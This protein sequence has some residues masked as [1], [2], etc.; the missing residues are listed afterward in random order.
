MESEQ[1]N[2]PQAALGYGSDMA[3]AKGQAAMVLG[4]QRRNRPQTAREQLQERIDGLKAS[5]E[6]H[7][8]ALAVLDGVPDVEK[9]LDALRRIGL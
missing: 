9:V 4:A 5:L 7:E 8:A 6:Q 3:Y 2:A 1:Y